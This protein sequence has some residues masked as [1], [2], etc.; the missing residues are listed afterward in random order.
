MR[1]CK[2]EVEATAKTKILQNLGLNLIN[3][4]SSVHYTGKREGH[5]YIWL[6]TSL[7]VKLSNFMCFVR[8]E[9]RKITFGIRVDN[10][11]EHHTILILCFERNLDFHHI[12]FRSVT[13]NT[14]LWQ[15]WCRR[16]RICFWTCVLT[17]NELFDL[18]FPAIKV[19]VNFFNIYKPFLKSMLWK[20]L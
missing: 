9:C 20:M 14:V 12:L 19:N 15:C 5:L 7:I 10:N 8:A 2:I 16:Q 17:L 4:I 1:N 6:S 11:R 13:N 3:S 18:F